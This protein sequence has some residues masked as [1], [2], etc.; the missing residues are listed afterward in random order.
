MTPLTSSSLY[1][2]GYPLTKYSIRPFAD[3]DITNDPAE[4]AE[5]KQWNSQLSHLRVAVENAFGRLK[6]RFPCLRNLPGHDV[7]EMF[8]TVEALLIVHNIVEEFGDD[9]T[10]IEGFNGIEDPGVN[11]VF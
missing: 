6:G 3:Y 1:F 10:N 4:S 2:T 9:P 8:R 11:D 7:R 5:R